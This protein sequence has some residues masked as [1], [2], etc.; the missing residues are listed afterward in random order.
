MGIPT[1]IDD[2]VIYIY[3]IVCIG[4]RVSSASMVWA[5]H[6]RLLHKNVGW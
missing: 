1:D 4:Y 2:L 6:R 3:M 5:H